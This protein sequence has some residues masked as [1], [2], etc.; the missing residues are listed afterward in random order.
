MAKR[1][2]R[3]VA[4]NMIL[5][6]KGSTEICQLTGMSRSTVCAIAKGL[7]VTM[8]RPGCKRPIRWIEMTCEQCLKSFRRRASQHNSEKRRRAK[9]RGIWGECYV[10]K[11]CSRRC[12]RDSIR[13]TKKQV[14][15]LRKYVQA[16]YTHALIG[17]FLNRP[18]TSVSMKCCELRLVRL[19]AFTVRELEYLVEYHGKKPLREIALDLERSKSGL[20]IAANR[21]GLT[22]KRRLTSEQLRR[23]KRLYRRGYSDLAIARRIKSC[24]SAIRRWRVRHKLPG[25]GW[26]EHSKNMLLASFERGGIGRS[27]ALK[28]HYAKMAA[29]IGEPEAKTPQEAR[30]LALL[31][32][33][34]MTSWE[35][36]KAVFG[37]RTST[38]ALARALRG[39]VNRGLVA[40]HREG[41]R[42]LYCRKHS[43]TAFD[44]QSYI[45]ELAQDVVENMPN[46]DDV[47]P[48][49]WEAIHELW[50]SGE[51]S[52]EALSLAGLGAVKKF[53][54]EMYSHLSVDGFVDMDG[55]AAFE[56]PDSMVH[57]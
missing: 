34:E 57:F 32:G 47:L 41:Q 55:E 19:R 15:L 4:K 24:Y 26:T 25:N 21:L 13:W 51:R 52:R 11:F 6:G 23:A 35:L 33:S 43:G 40:K 12:Y 44:S 9:S 2:E 8:P 14:R 3:E 18:K 5:S 27:A 20:Q 56:V 54:A 7:G 50:E 17:K 39:L 22:R 30:V 28:Q 1:D 42:T 53:N 48:V 38:G 10:G 46:C 36:R 16:G 45:V 29:A 49:A 37:K 31:N